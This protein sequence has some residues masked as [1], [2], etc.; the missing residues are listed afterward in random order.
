MAKK[1][2]VA[3]QQQST[4]TVAATPVVVSTPAPAP[5][6]EPAAPK[7]R[8]ARAT[9][10][11][12]KASKAAAAPSEEVVVA[13]QAATPAVEVATPSVRRVTTRDTVLED[14][15]SLMNSIQ[16]ELARA[17]EAGEK[18]VSFKFMR[19]VARQLGQLKTHS[20]KVMK[21]RRVANPEKTHNSIFQLAVPISEELANFNG[22]NPS[23]P[24]SRVE[25]TRAL[26]KYIKDNN[27][28]DQNDRRIILVDAKLAKLLNYTPDKDTAPLNYSRLQSYMKVHFLPGAGV[29][30]AAAVVRPVSS[31][32]RSKTVASRK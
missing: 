27:L 17:R 10:R 9:P 3:K 28:Q 8:A 6:T 11:A 23:E 19:S 4:T 5:V 2:V 7:K 26:C 16:G 20:Q 12:S 1:T 30:A 25:V 18:A 13:Q 31:P 14:F 24:K 29:A 15:D 32:K 22:W 21:K